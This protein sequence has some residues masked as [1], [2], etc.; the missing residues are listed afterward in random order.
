MQMAVDIVADSPH[1]SNKIAACVAGETP[2]GKAFAVAR[3][4]YWPAPIEA[5][6]GH[7]VKI[8]N[9][10]GTLHAETAC[11]ID[12]AMEAGT[13]TKGAQIFITDPPCPNCAKNI[14]EAGITEVYIDH[15]GFDKDW[16]QRRGDDFAAMALRIFEN[17]G[18]A[19]YEIRRK[20]Q[21]ITPI[22]EVSPDYQPPL[23]KPAFAQNLEDFDFEALIAQQAQ[24]YGEE[25]FGLA[26]AEDT[27]GQRFALSAEPHFVIGYT[28]DTTDE[29][30]G[31]Y[32]FILEPMNRLIMTAA[33]KGL[34]LDPAYVY[35]SRIPT[36][37]ELVNMVGAG[38]VK[39]TIGDRS[40]C[41]DER[42]LEAL[43]QLEEAGIVR[44]KNGAN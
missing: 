16:V 1:P 40:A 20:D 24:I 35:S 32:S 21:V 37:R 29:P 34:K 30:D 9:S 18:I 28:G 44:I 11:I 39:L 31:K 23:E 17:A 41:R 2:G 22:L 12:V 33:R 19:V 10:S 26:I 43:T 15:K 42:G 13:R 25:P 5:A 27:R 4:N 8:G 6:F 14:A 36:A 7:E 3:T 38:L